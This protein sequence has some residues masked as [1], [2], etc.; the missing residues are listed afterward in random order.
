[1]SRQNVEIVRELFAGFA[2]RDH[3][4]AFEVYYPDI[5]WHASNAWGLNP[6][7]A[8]VHRGH[9]GVRTYWRGWLSAWMSAR[10]GACAITG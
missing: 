4:R 10:P 7:L 9:D 1:V 3:E 5:E 6:D 8:R 2:K